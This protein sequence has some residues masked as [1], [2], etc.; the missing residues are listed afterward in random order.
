MSLNVLEQIAAASG[1]T[2][3]FNI[4]KSNSGNKEL[5][6]ILDAV[7]NYKRRFFVNKF[8]MPDPATTHTAQHV[9]FMKILNLLENRVIT[10]NAAKKTVEEFF[11]YCDDLHQGWYAKILRKDLKCGFSEKTAVKA[12]FTNIPLFDVMLAKDGKQCKQLEN[13]L[14]KGVFVSPKLDGYR[15]LAVIVDGS[16]TLY[17]RNGTVY[18]NFPSIEKSL[19]EC[20][21]IG[22]FV[23]DGEIMSDDFQAMQ[24]SAFANKRG[25]TVGDV[26][27]HIFG[28][29]PY[30]EWVS[31]K[32]K[33]LTADRLVELSKLAKNFDKRLIQVH[34]TLVNDEA[35]ILAMELQY[36]QQGYEGAMALPNIP[37]YLGKKTNKLL[38][39]KTML[40]DDCVITGMYEGKPGTRLEGSMGGIVVKQENG[41]TCECGTGFSDEDRRYMWDNKDEF[42]G[43]LC[44]L[45]YQ[46]LTKDN[47]LRFP[48]FMR[49]RNDK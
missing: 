1:K 23:F 2:D 43:R 3:K 4:L 20:F 14:A 25:T 49:W 41:E 17:S 16:V 5:A 42:I 21:P 34:H 36:I 27:F 47:I 13:L 35:S 24:K 22:K 15:C 30:Q 32:F 11:S 6:D 45:K 31:Q 28:Y 38:K 44:E 39:F 29:I 26:Q 40:S 9:D 33:M 48:V 8:D 10:G 37:Y 12:G 7:F 46:E 19:S 18:E